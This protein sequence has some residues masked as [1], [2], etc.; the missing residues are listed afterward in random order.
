MAS[1]RI[2][3]KV[4]GIAP[5][6]PVFS[7]AI[8]SNGVVYCSGQIGARPDGTMVEGPIEGRVN[9]IMDNLDAVLKAHGS[10]LEHTVKFTIF[11][12]S[13]SIFAD[14][15][16]AY[17]KRVPSPAPARSCIGVASL[18]RGTDIEIECVAIVPGRAKL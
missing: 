11:I 7:P 2:A 15:N 12:T 5:P 16:A 6:L 17:L 18:P 9:Q 3:N 13:Y 1:E 14:L 10:G 4:E 8:L